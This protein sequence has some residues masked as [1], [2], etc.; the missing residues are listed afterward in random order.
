MNGIEAVSSSRVQDF[1]K[2]AREKFPRIHR[3][4]RALAGRPLIL[5]DYPVDPKPR[6]GFGKPPHPELYQLLNTQRGGYME[7]VQSFA[8]FAPD[9]L[10]IPRQGTESEIG[11][12]MR[13]L[14]PLDAATLYCMLRSYDPSIYF[15][16]GS[17]FSTRVAHRAITDGKLRTRIISLD[18]LPQTDVDRM[19][20]EVIRQPL[21]N[22]DLS[23]TER[24]NSG[25]FLFIDNSHC[26]FPNSDVTVF[27]LEV[28]PR[29]QPGVIVHIH[30]IAL[31]Y[32]YAPEWKERFYSEQYLLACCLLNG[33]ERFRILL[34]NNFISMDEELS[35]A[36]DWLWGK[37]LLQGVPRRGMSFW[38]IR[39]C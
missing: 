22:T 26:C 25:D 3:A 14:P 29:L 2:W 16:V 32:D 7:L 17:G 34:P 6:Y 5:L 28:L 37:D 30:D 33:P 36:W 19:C 20:D 23:W 15:E 39:I 4:K 21:E 9:L 24:L 11:W 18:P 12:L 38:F 13:M 27:F 1:R 35:A 10:R 8:R 31:P